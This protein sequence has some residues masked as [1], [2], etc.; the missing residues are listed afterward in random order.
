MSSNSSTIALA[1]RPELATWMGSPS[2][3]QIS[4]PLASAMLQEKSRAVL[5]TIE[6]ADRSRV[7][8]ICREMASNLLDSTTI[9]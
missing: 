2:A 9:R 1:T 5:T 7:L 3:R 6:R 8:V 4:R